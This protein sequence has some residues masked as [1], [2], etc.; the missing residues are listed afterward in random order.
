M[1]AV[2]V[3]SAL[4]VSHLQGDRTIYMYIVHCAILLQLQLK[5]LGERV[6]NAQIRNL[7]ALNHV[8]RMIVWIYP[9]T[10]TTHFTSPTAHFA[11]SPIADYYPLPSTS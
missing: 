2:H 3:H 7:E 4:L 6:E 11:T 10:P 5:S 8:E 9:P 1:Y